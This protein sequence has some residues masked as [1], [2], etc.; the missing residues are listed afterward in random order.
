MAKQDK[1][2]GSK[3][4][5]RN[6]NRCARYRARSNAGNT[7]KARRVMR[8]LERYGTSSLRQRATEKGK[9]GGKRVGVVLKPIKQTGNFI[10]REKG[11]RVVALDSARKKRRWRRAA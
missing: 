5:G 3:K 6:S 2:G 4:Y 9:K 1:G 11:D 8:E 7:P 10:L